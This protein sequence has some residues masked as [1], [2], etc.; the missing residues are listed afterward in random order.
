MPD[1]EEQQPQTEPSEEAKALHGA[2][3]QPEQYEQPAAVAL[4]GDT[5]IAREE[6]TDD[7]N[8][9]A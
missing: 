4:D 8:G 3:A 9:N 1:H 5:L 7:E 2:K 6:A